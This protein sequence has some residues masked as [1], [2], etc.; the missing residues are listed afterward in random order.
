MPLNDTVDGNHNLD[1]R[2]SNMDVIGDN[3]WLIWAYE[4]EAVLCCHREE[5]FNRSEESMSED[6]ITV[7]CSLPF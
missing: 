6:E 1:L 5:L 4:L 2:A 7:T 3:E